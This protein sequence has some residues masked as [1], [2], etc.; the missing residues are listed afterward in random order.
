MNQFSAGALTRWW[1]TRQVRIAPVAC[2]RRAR[3]A[4]R[5]LI[6]AL[7]AAALVLSGIVEAQDRVA[8]RGGLQFN[9]VFL[10]PSGGPVVPFFDGWY[11]NP[12]GSFELVFGYYNVNT[13]EI[14]DVPIGPDNI[15]EPR[16]F[17]GVQPTHFLPVPADDHRYRGVFTVTVPA[18]AAD[19]DVV[20]T[21]RSGEQ[22]H[23][24]PGRVTSPS[25]ELEGWDQPGRATVAPT[26][27]LEASGPAAQGPAGIVAAPLDAKVGAPLPLTVWTT[28]RN[29][30]R[31]RDT[32]P[33]RV[34]WF[35]HQGSGGVTFSRPDVQVALDGDGTA[36]TDATFDEPGDYVVRVLA[37]N[38]VRDFEFYCCWTNGFVRVTVRP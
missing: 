8:D 37:F 11:D 31:E 13:E 25:Y 38:T 5:R 26:L 19:R 4:T 16:E 35:K 10:R 14:L 32:V 33:V 22:T 27:R 18:D 28:R 6:C 30:Y 12:N 34:A 23:S 3:A 36:M 9:P 1:S 24:V 7:S 17:D 20:W 29:P 15:I 2:V 21:L